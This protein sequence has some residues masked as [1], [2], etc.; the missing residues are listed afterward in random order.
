MPITPAEFRHAMS[1]HASGVTVVVVRDASGAWHGMT[2]TSVTSLSLEPPMVLACIGFDAT[3][4]E[5]I[6]KA[7]RFGVTFLAESQQ[8]DA[9][10]YADR[11]RH[12]VTGNPSLSPNGIPLLGGIAHLDVKRADIFQ[13]GD[14]SIVTGVVEWM[15]T[16]GGKPL[17]H[18]H[19][20]YRGIRP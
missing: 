12:L 13:G 7:P 11:E 4:H 6:V 20:R 16:P 18:F 17:L 19:S 3:I 8:E 15:D 14:H 10:R 9:E 5:V 2:A 1:H